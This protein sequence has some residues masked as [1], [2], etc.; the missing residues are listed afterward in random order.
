MLRKFFVR[1][2]SSFFVEK[3]VMHQNYWKFY[4]IYGFTLNFYKYNFDIIEKKNYFNSRQRILKLSKID[5]NQKKICI[6]NFIKKFYEICYFF[7]SIIKNSIVFFFCKFKIIQP[8]QQFFP[9]F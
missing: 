7:R 8:F 6:Y 4:W 3:K 1:F 9:V 5:L 2:T